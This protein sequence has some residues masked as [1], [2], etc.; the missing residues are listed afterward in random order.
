MMII[1]LSQIDMESSISYLSKFE[2][3]AKDY[4]FYF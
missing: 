3:I 2:E 4:G 1:L